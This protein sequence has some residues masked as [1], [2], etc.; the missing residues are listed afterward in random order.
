MKTF[1]VVQVDG[2]TEWATDDWEQ[3]E[4]YARR[5]YN[6]SRRPHVVIYSERRPDHR[7]VALDFGVR[8]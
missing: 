1:Y 3:A 5:R 6:N 2:S 4:S 7:K 8:R